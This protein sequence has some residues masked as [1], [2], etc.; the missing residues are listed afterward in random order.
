MR[1]AFLVLITAM[2]VGCAASPT[3]QLTP[4]EIQSL[5]TK[6]YETSK[7]IAFASTLSVF[8]DLGYIIES[9][10]ESTGFITATSPTDTKLNWWTWAQDSK[11]TR[12]TAFVE[13][14]RQNYTRVR[15]TFVNSTSS[16][17]SYGQYSEK[18]TVILVAGP[19]EAVFNRVGN[20]IFVRKGSN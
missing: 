15:V 18:D 12:V 9:A 1:Y 10:D 20:E 16:S 4:L 14:L 7:H 11:T 13:E 5:Q 17:S 19:Y 3:T 8:Q 6:E 2:L